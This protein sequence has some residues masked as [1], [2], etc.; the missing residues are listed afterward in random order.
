MSNEKASDALNIVANALVKATGKPLSYAQH[1]QRVAAAKSAAEKRR[2]H[3]AAYQHAARHARHWRE[4]KGA[5]HPE[6][7][8]WTQRARLH[9]GH[10]KAHDDAVD[11]VKQMAKQDVKGE[12]GGL[13]RTPEASVQA[14]HEFGQDNDTGEDQHIGRIGHDLAA[15]VYKTAAEEAG[16]TWNRRHR[17]SPR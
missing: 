4:F 1:E 3:G 16:H 14:W 8:K 11:A 12:T 13:M 7:Q 2:A 6:T 17:S 15:Q 10:V 9:W 5:D